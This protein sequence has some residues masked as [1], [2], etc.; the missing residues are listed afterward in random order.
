MPIL[1]KTL[2]FLAIFALTLVVA[3]TS[4]I[5]NYA[6]R[7][8]AQAEGVSVNLTNIQAPLNNDSTWKWR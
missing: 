8:R 1:K 2:P 7:A 4:F 6:E 3:G 5:Q